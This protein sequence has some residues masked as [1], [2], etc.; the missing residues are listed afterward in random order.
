MKS[1][2]IINIEDITDQMIHDSLN[3]P[4][5]FRT[6]LDG[7]KA[8]LKFPTAFPDIMSG[9]IKYTHEEILEILD[10]PEW[11]EETT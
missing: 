2:I 3:T 7:T 1:Y 5:S 4:S 10:G 8:V 11:T 6:S 9:Q